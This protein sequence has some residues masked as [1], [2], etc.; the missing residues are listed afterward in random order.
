MADLFQALSDAI[1]VFIT[2]LSVGPLRSASSANNTPTSNR[3]T[4]SPPPHSGLAN[5]LT[6]SS[7]TTSNPSST[8][9]SQPSS[10]SSAP[11]SASNSPVGV[12]KKAVT[13]PKIVTPTGSPGILRKESHQGLL[14][15]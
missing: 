1:T 6:S 14:I 3:R 11:T 8:T 5:C 7:P 4:M 10:I 12:M 13:I 9:N 2:V 15:N